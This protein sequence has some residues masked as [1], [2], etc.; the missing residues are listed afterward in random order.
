MSA[1][2]S[3]RSSTTPNDEEEKKVGADLALKG[4]QRFL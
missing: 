3:S 1:E 4:F 2:D